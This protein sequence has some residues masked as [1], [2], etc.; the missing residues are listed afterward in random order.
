METMILKPAYT[1]YYLLSCKVKCIL[2]DFKPMYM[3]VLT[4]PEKGAFLRNMITLVPY[5]EEKMLFLITLEYRK[6]Q[7]HPTSCYVI[8]EGLPRGGEAPAI[9]DLYMLNNF[10]SQMITLSVYNCWF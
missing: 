9:H 10:T 1:Y 8:R 6:H 3:C 7:W 5:K 4:F 2:N